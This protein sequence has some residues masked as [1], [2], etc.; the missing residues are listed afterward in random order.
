[1]LEQLIARIILAV[2][3]CVVLPLTGAT[4][5]WPLEMQIIGDQLI[6]SGPIEIG[7]S[8]KFFRLQ[9]RNTLRTVILKDS[10]GGDVET[11]IDIARQIRSSGLNT[12]ISGYCF[13]SCSTIFV[14]GKERY[15]S[16]GQPIA[17]TWV[18]FN[19]SY[20]DRKQY[21]NAATG[22]LKRLYGEMIGDKLDESLVDVW[23]NSPRN[24]GVFFFSPLL[25]SVSVFSC[26]GNEPKGNRFA[27]CEKV[28]KTAL[29]L[30]IITS[31]ELIEVHRVS[32]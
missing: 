29:D 10:N 24:G 9:Q 3:A 22:R 5:A 13:S 30:G 21:S 28:A 6:L 12:A 25:G 18:G 17:K 1:M 20:G 32:L 11:G 4:K 31:V 15:F 2:C 8:G 27:Y 19:S 16:S 7:D 23:L 14:G 26:S